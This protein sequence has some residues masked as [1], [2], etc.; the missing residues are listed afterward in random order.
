MKV[1]RAGDRAG[2]RMSRRTAV[3]IMLYIGV[4]AMAMVTYYDYR[5]R[6]SAAPASTVFEPDEIIAVELHRPG[7]QTIALEK[8][9]TGWAITAPIDRAAI[10]RRVQLLLSMAGFTVESA[11]D[12]GDLDPSELGLASPL[13]TISL[14]SSEGEIE[15]LIGGLGPNNKR[16]YVQIERRIWLKDDLFLPLI[17]G[18]LN[19]FA[20]LGLLPGDKKLVRVVSPLDDTASTDEVF[21]RWAL[22]RAAAI[23]PV[24]DLA[25]TQL[26]YVTLEFADGSVQPLKMARS[27]RQI[28]LLPEGAN[29]ALLLTE[30]QSVALGLIGKPD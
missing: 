8:N 25:T 28:A 11:Y 23:A 20:N 26:V 5:D 24:A 3:N 12:A 7:H 29:Y 19:T 4:L 2:Y 18:G 27:G 16:R 30:T 21:D 10:E 1:S 13:A 14:I 6:N 17:T 22:A 9:S 15:A